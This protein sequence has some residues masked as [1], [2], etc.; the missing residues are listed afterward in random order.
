MKSKVSF[1]LAV[2]MLASLAVLAL[3]SLAAGKGQKASAKEL[4]WHGTLVRKS[5]DGS[6]LTVRKTGVEKEIHITS[7]TKWTKTEKGKAVE[8][9]PKDVKE[10]SDVICI[11]KSNDKKEFEATRIDL[12]LPK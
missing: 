5:S 8:I 3:P 7:E 2:V 1:G 9:D 10:G 4:R 6:V 12:R 11:G